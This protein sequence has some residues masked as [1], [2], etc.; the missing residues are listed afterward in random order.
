M[1]R[2]FSFDFLVY[3]RIEM[4]YNGGYYLEHKIYRKI[5]PYNMGY[6]MCLVY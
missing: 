2:R 3:N 4:G 5:Y 1:I 6:R